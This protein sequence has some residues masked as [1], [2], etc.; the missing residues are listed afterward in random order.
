MLSAQLTAADDLAADNQALVRVTSRRR[1]SVF[2][3]AAPSAPVDVVRKTLE[4]LPGIDLQVVEQL[5]VTL[6]PQSLVVLHGQVPVSLP[7]CPLLVITPQGSCD[8]WDTAGSVPEGQC[9]VQSVRRDLPLLAGIR[10]E[11][12][13]VEEAVKLQFKDPA[14]TLVAAT[15]GDPLYSLVQRTAGPVLVLHVDLRKDKS[16]FALRSDFPRLIEQAVRWL[17]GTAD[18][19]TLA[20]GSDEPVTKP[21]RSEP[22]PEPV[23]IVNRVESDIR[24]GAKVASRDVPSPAPTREQP[25]WMLLAGLAV[26]LLLS[27]WCLFHRRVV[28]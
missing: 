9:D 4:A 13:V 18:S 26:V 28:V 15:S 14:Q 11:D 25:L 16:D 22:S 23:N 1:P 12:V 6:P 19:V 17:T 2:L 24:A 27:E 5:P 20:V 7:P 21:G 3:S 10:F 8:L